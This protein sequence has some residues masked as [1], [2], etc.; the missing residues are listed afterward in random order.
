MAQ[1]MRVALVAFAATGMTAIGMAGCANARDYTLKFERAA[2]ETVF[3]DKKIAFGMVRAT[4]SNPNDF[5][6]W[7]RTRQR[8]VTLDGYSTTPTSAQV[9]TMIAPR[10]K[11]TIASETILL[12][13]LSPAKHRGHMDFALC[14]GR[15]ANAL[16]KGQT[17]SVPFQAAYASFN[18]MTASFGAAKVAD[19]ACR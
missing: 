15:A 3:V 11:T 12:N 19:S 14:Y 7:V 13:K 4:I 10:S 16:T 9:E 8:K 18:T 6:V 2:V 1:S 5:P 17:I